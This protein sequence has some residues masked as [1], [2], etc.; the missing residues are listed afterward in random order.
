M[1][2]PQPRLKH[3]RGAKLLRNNANTRFRRPS[4]LAVLALFRLLE[5]Q[6]TRIRTGLDERPHKGLVVDAIAG[7]HGVEAPRVGGAGQGGRDLVEFPIQRDEMD[8]PSHS[9]PLPLPS[10]GRTRTLRLASLTRRG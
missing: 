7:H 8:F 2:S 1:E 10:G 4:S 3:L 6:P 9:F 5:P